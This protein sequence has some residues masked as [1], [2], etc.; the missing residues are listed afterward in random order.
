MAKP[1]IKAKVIITI[2]EHANGQF[3]FACSEIQGK[4]ELLNGLAHHVALHLPR[5]V[6]AA[7]RDFLE[8]KKDS[9]NASFH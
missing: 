4:S 1:A 2:K 3:E 7:A 8:P 9:N 5:T 6:A